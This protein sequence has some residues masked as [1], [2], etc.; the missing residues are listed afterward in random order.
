MRDKIE[1][2][3]CQNEC[4]MIDLQEVS[5]KFHK[6][7]IKRI[8]YSLSHRENEHFIAE[9]LYS[10]KYSLRKVMSRIQRMSS[11]EKKFETQTMLELVDI[12]PSLL[13]DTSMHHFTFEKIGLNNGEE[14]LV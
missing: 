4:R 2:C 11:Q 3:I 1:A 8:K 14:S 5:P 12:M 10:K 7:S 6:F 9:K 13:V